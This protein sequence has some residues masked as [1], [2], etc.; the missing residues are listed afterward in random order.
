MGSPER[1]TLPAAHPTARPI[2]RHGLNARKM[3]P[4]STLAGTSPIQKTTNTKVGA[5]LAAGLCVPSSP[6]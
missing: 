6:L 1:A 4:N 3:S 5:K 2:A